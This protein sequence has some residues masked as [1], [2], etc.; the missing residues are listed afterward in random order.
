MGGL[1]KDYEDKQDAQQ[2]RIE[3]L[4]QQFLVHTDSD[5]FNQ[6]KH[7]VIVPATKHFSAIN[8]VHL[9]TN[10]QSYLKDEERTNKGERIALVT[11]ILINTEHANLFWPDRCAIFSWNEETEEVQSE[12]F[13][14]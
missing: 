4:M 8:T 2:V 5:N 14:V 12:Q 1:R 9:Q 11:G 7:P 3:Q 10:I 6:G 13:R